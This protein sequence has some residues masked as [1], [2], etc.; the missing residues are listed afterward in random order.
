M[1]KLIMTSAL[2]MVV[3]TMLA[4]PIGRDAAM[5]KAQAFMQDV[6]PKATLNMAPA[7]RKAMG[8]NGNQAYYIFNAE[9]NQ[10]FVI[11][12]GDDRSEEVLGYSDTG[13][14]DLNNMPDALRDMLDCFVDELQELDEAGITSP[15]AFSRG[16]NKVVSTGRHPI[17]PMTTSLWTQGAPFNN[18]LPYYTIEGYTNQRPPVGCGI[19]AIAQMI[20]F[21][22]YAHMEY[23]IPSY[24]Q[25]T[26][27]FVGTMP[28]LEKR[29]WDFSK[30]Y[31]T[32]SYNSRDTYI[33]TFMKYILTAMQSRFGSTTGTSTSPD[34]VKAR[35]E[36]YFN[37]KM[38]YVP[39]ANIKPYEFEDFTYNDLRQG[40]PVLMEGTASSGGHYFIADGYSYDGFFHF[41]WGWE[42]LCNGYFRLSP[43]S[44]HNYA[45]S[46]AYSKVLIGYFGFRPNDGRLDN[47]EDPTKNYHS[48]ETV[49]NYV[50]GMR[51]LCFY[52][53]T[54]V[55]P[56]KDIANN[57]SLIYSNQ[58][59]KRAS[60]GTFSFGKNQIRTYLENWTDLEFTMKRIF[61]TEFAILDKDYNVIGT[62]GTK[63][64]TIAANKKLVVYYDLKKI[65]L[66]AGDGEYY[67]VHRSKANAATD[68]V[69]HFSETKGTYDHIKAVVK[70]D[71]LTLSLVP[72]IEFDLAKTEL[73]GQCAKGWRTGVRFY[74][75]N[76]SFNKMLWN[77]SLYLDKTT[78][79]KTYMQD[80][81]ELCL[82]AKSSGYIELDF[83]PGSKNGTLFLVNKDRGDIIDARYNFMLKTAATPNLSYSWEMDNASGST[84]YGNEIHGNIK[85][86]NNSDADFEDVFTL[87]T[88][89][90][91]TSYNGANKYVCSV[92][93][94]HIPA[95]GSAYISIDKMNY[96][97]LFDVYDGGLDYGKVVSFSLC[98]GEG[99]TDDNIVSEKSYT[100]T[101]AVLW[102]DKTGKMH[103]VAPVTNRYTVPAEAVAISFVDSKLSSW[104]GYNYAIPSTITPNN[105]PNCIYY[106]YQNSHAQK[107]INYQSK[108]IVVNGV[109][110]NNIHFSDDY[111]AYV[112]ITF[113]ANKKVSY[114]RNFDYGYEGNNDEQGW[115]TIC[116]PFTVEKIHN[117]AQDMDVDWYHFNGDTG[118]NFWLRKYYGEEFRTLYYD[119][120]D[121]FEAN[122]PYVI[123]MPGNYYKKWGEKWCLTGK[124]IVFS[125]ENTEV[126]S[127]VEI[128]D[129]NNYNLV[130]T[131]TA[132]KYNAEK[133]LYGMD[134][135]GNKYTY[136]STTAGAYKGYKP[137]R[138]YLTSESA[139]EKT[140]VTQIRIVQR[141]GFDSYEGDLEETVTGIGSMHENSAAEASIYNLNGV[142]VGTV[143][144]GNERQALQNL[145][146]GLYIINGKKYIK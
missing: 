80:N 145:P 53:G 10:G 87:M 75:K 38:N 37:Y 139:P 143:K 39:R 85:V 4:N 122:V 126:R 24:E 55:D 92:N 136:L 97:D 18:Q 135:P 12:S 131:T 113:K 33:G 73:I 50:T 125:A 130:S 29:E 77:Y 137:F 124:D 47:N 70:N 82:Q 46:H 20:Y 88:R 138:G 9:D 6:N 2:S 19:C 7:P 8:K 106:F 118:K 109:A 21:W 5:Q 117:A 146:S 13:C 96:S 144:K 48:Y 64:A 111:A 141:V 71:Q 132:T 32:Y 98:N 72:A 54:K 59:A 56:S 103:A 108:N 35:I 95:H 84:L 25:N 43:L 120:T 86:T 30:L 102:W 27:V 23:D 140:G 62:F 51:T 67:F 66:P 83:T 61:D 52:D 104:W 65:K 93:P 76:N 81:K 90:G 40:M 57:D 79:D 107:L 121:A 22:K 3:T 129:C 31:D 36:K 114:T 11:V 26:K 127:G 69:F 34:K 44:C 89:T 112:P 16:A 1:K 45:T 94:I 41:N 116:L 78:P 14:I 42:G 91:T 63:K 28:A 142:K 123:C 133:Y 60:D 128:V 101:P 49:Y 115:S 68:G 110:P 74:A 58:T 134:E 100:V 15:E 17:A 105:N 119:Y 99:I